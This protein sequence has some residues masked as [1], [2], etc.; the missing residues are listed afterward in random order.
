MLIHWLKPLYE[1]DDPAAPQGGT[2]KTSAVLAEYGND[3]I[4]M[5]E[6]LAEFQADNFKL[7]EE[8]R[9]LKQQLSDLSGKVPAEGA[10]VLIGDEATAYDAYVALGKADEIKQALA[11]RATLAERVATRERADTIAAVAQAAG[12]DPDVLAQLAG[13][14]PLSVKDEGKDKDKKSVPYIADADGKEHRLTDYAQQH[15]TKFLPALAPKGHGDGVGS[16]A[17]GKRPAALDTEVRS[18]GIRF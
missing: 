7:R 5:A 18:P 17:N 14:A 10:K 4:R 12:F 6:K 9:T 13:A 8:R 3:A 2:A 11:E 1:G 16:P 15:W